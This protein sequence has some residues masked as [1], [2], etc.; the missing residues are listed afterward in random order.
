[1]ST[2]GQKNRIKDFFWAIADRLV[3][4]GGDLA[5][6]IADAVRQPF[7][8]I[9]WGLRRWLVWPLQD[10]LPRPEGAGRVLA[11]A[12]AVVLAVGVGVGGFAWVASNGSS[13]LSASAATEASFAAT[14][15]AAEAGEPQAPEPT[16]HG[17]A[18]VF[19]PAPGGSSSARS[20]PAKAEPALPS[21]APET[22][23]PATDAIASAPSAGASTV[24]SAPAGKAVVGVAREFADAFVVYETGGLEPAVRRTFGK[25]ATPQL[26]KSLLRR[27]PRLPADV[28][29]P[30]AKVLN[31]V[32]G[33][34]NGPVQTVSV[35]LLRLGVT[36]E[37]RLDVEL[38][39]GDHQWRVS[40]VLG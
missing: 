27:P 14:P 21:S 29:V 7:E 17:A 31:V 30:R 8:R 1:M 13:E 3:V 9:G 32:A 35:S 38:T 10:R 16:L 25:T 23:S 28:K 36:S 22:S 15:I 33:P 12:A 34:S 4:D 18:P 19:K 5:G 37:L 24:V 40:N 2:R 20:G 6:R 26:S 11:F 39:K